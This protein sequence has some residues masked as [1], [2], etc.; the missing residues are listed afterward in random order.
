MPKPMP[1]KARKAADPFADKLYAYRG[2]VER[3]LDGDTLDLVVDLGM[4]VKMDLR[5]R[6]AGVNAN[7]H[8]TAAGDHATAA[9]QAWVAAHPGPY[10]IRTE[11]DNAEKFG[12]MMAR[13]VAPDGADLIA[14]MKA[15]GHVVAWDG[16]GARP[17]PPPLTDVVGNL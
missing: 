6:L 14:D 8:N 7:E 17:L 15:A 9:V 1:P 16:Q 11:K 12:R 4:K 13:V 10:L 2:T 5:V 3:V